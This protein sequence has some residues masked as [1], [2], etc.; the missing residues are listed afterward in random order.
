MLLFKYLDNLPKIPEHLL[1][2]HIDTDGDR[3]YTA[4]M[5][6]MTSSHGD[7]PNVLYTRHT[8]EG[9]LA[10][11]IAENIS[12]KL[13]LPS[14]QISQYI[15]GSHTHLA[16]TDSFPRKWVIN[17]VYD[18]GGENP[19]TNF[20]RELG[21]PVIRPH[22]TK[23]ENQDRLKLIKSVHV[24]T[25]R[26]W[27]INALVVHDVNGITGRRTAVTAGVGAL[28][29]FSVLKGYENISMDN[30]VDDE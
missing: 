1:P 5:R 21:Q 8:A 18:K 4:E 23:P 17:Y 11:W 20:Y 19:S 14:V 22:L 2:Q 27:L 3:N 7:I 30:V 13:F 26:W 12:D 6:T 15:G 10:K 16:H 9:E 25:H 28:N 24:D 29:P